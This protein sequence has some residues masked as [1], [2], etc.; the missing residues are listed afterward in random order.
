MRCI[1]PLSQFVPAVQ[2]EFYPHFRPGLVILGQSLSFLKINYSWFDTQTDIDLML[3]LNNPI[4]FN[5]ACQKM[6]KLKQPTTI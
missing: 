2:L 1:R 5:G 3:F 4:E 6:I